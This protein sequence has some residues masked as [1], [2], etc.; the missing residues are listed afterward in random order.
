MNS[1]DSDSDEEKDNGVRT[2][3]VQD[4]ERRA[5]IDQMVRASNRQNAFDDQ[6]VTDFV[7]RMAEKNANPGAAAARPPPEFT[8]GDDDE[9]DEEQDELEVSYQRKKHE[10]KSRSPEEYPP[11]EAYAGDE[12]EDGDE[13]PSYDPKDDDAIGYGR[14]C[15]V[16]C[17]LVIAMIATSVLI[18]IFVV[19]ADGE[20]GARHHN[21][22]DGMILPFA[23][24]NLSEICS[25]DA[26]KTFQGVLDCREPCMKAACCWEKG[27]N[28]QQ[29][30]CW[31]SHPL[32]CAPYES[33]VN[34]LTAGSEPRPYSDATT[35][36]GGSS[37]SNSRP[38]STIP[39]APVG[40]DACNSFDINSVE[41]VLKCEDACAKATCCWKKN[42]PTVDSCPTDPNCKGYKLCEILNTGGTATGSGT[43]TT[44]EIP[45]P[46]STINDDC[47]EPST[48]ACLESCMQA[49]CCWMAATITYASPQGSKITESVL[50]T[51][52]HQKEC[53]PYKPCL[54]ISKEAVVTHESN[55]D[56]P[57][58]TGLDTVCAN[59]LDGTCRDACNKAP[60]CWQLATTTF[61][62]EDGH[63]VYE[64]VQ[65][66]C[67]QREEC[68][69]YAA[70]KQLPE[71]DGPT[72]APA[73]VPEPLES[74]LASVCAQSL[75]GT[76]RQECHRATCCWKLATTSYTGPEGN[77]ITE[78]VMGS[79]SHLSECAAYEPCKQL[80]EA[81]SS[82]TFDI[83][84]A[85]ADL[86][87]RC[88]NSLDGY[89][90]DTCEQATCCWK[91]AT[92]QYSGP[93]G[94]SVTEHVRG[95]CS[96]RDECVGYEACQKL[97]EAND[98]ESAPH[99][100]V[101]TAPSNLDQV[102]HPAPEAMDSIEACVEYCD[103]ATCCWKKATTSH[104]N[105]SGQTVTAAVSGTCSHQPECDAYQAC[106]VLDDDSISPAPAPTATSAPV[107]SPG[108]DVEYT[109]AVIYD[110]CWNHEVQGN[111]PNLCEQ[112]CTPGACC[113]KDGEGPCDSGFDCTKYEP[114]DKLVDGGS[115]GQPSAIETACSNL[116][117][118][119]DCIGLCAKGTCCF[120]T[121]LG[122]TCDVA[123]PTTICS[124]YTPCEIIYNSVANGNNR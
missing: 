68:A 71:A 67:S 114:C 38:T 16:A 97:P 59:S 47:S 8:I 48:D 70:C 118:L 94:D 22:F 109:E 102:C 92:T 78:T 104:T 33:C 93:M 115:D 52:S 56:I 98:A 101:P 65:G 32:E 106:S 119:A 57:R 1:Y 31:E 89:C 69:D 46:P 80:S 43:T 15:C 29:P 62:G 20:E 6:D 25:K 123:A 110:V 82:H 83:P 121:D 50:G 19:I 99:V 36:S 60:C 100:Y 91:M 23:P 37:S 17:A 11:G 42:D 122:K 7:L 64:A 79:C 112:V 5:R 81:T 4:P 53:A 84:P 39:V 45:S 66:I 74:D 55:S 12:M 10:Y 108:S 86:P 87:S 113:W 30:V 3:E 72:T 2:Q 95:S 9:D 76:C 18:L 54:S 34:L 35:G 77:T 21:G 90:R 85:P 58:V 88:D 124:Q 61:T 51:C 40:V 44:Q 107:A 116:E 26:V 73:P 117:D 103:A 63:Q 41:D 111:G 105:I 14:L 75:D 49:T 27:E 28:G 24:S 13:I 120:T 96:H